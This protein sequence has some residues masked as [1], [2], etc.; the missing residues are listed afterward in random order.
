VNDRLKCY[1]ACVLWLQLSSSSDYCCFRA[2][3]LDVTLGY[4]PGKFSPWWMT[5]SVELVWSGLGLTLCTVV[6]RSYDV[7]SVNTGWLQVQQTTSTRPVQTTHVGVIIIV[8]VVVFARCRILPAENQTRPRR[9]QRYY[10]RDSCCW[11]QCCYEQV[12]RF[13]EKSQDWG[14]S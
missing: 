13:G 8:V 1:N 10:T 3:T 6:G 7:V 2:M 14:G 9:H 4:K 11:Q 5:V 12:K